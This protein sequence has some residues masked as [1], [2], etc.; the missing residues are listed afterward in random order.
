[1]KWSLIGNVASFGQ[2]YFE[3]LVIVVLQLILKNFGFMQ[4]TVS[5]PFLK[6]IQ[7]LS[8]TSLI[9][10]LFGV[11]FLNFIFRYLIVTS[12]AMSSILISARLRMH[13]Y[14]ELLQSKKPKFIPASELNYR[15]TELAQRTAC[16][17][18]LVVDL[19]NVL[20]QV[21]VYIAIMACLSWKLTLIGLCALGLLG[22]V[23]MKI[24][25]SIQPFS[26]Q[27]PPEVRAINKSIQRIAR[28]WLLVNILRTNNVE[29]EHLINKELKYH[30]LNL[31]IIFL[32]FLSSELP[33]ILGSG[34]IVGMII[35][36][37]AIFQLPAHVLISFVYL[38][39]RLSQTIG[40]M[41]Q[42]M[43]TLIAQYPFFKETLD[44]YDV[45]PND[46]KADAFRPIQLIGM[47]KPMTVYHNERIHLYRNL[48]EISS[49]PCIEI[50]NVTFSY[51]S[52]AKTIFENL[53]LKIE[54]GEQ[55]GI[56]GRSGA[57]K[58][59]ILG[60]I[61]GLLEPQ[62]GQVLINNEL[63][64]SFF[65]KYKI[66]VGYVGPEPFLIEGTLLDNLLYGCIYEKPSDGQINHALRM[67][68]LYDF[69][70]T[71]PGKLYYKVNENGDGLSAGQKQRLALARSLLLNPKLVIL[72]EVSA[73]LDKET[74]FEITE[75]L[76]DLRGQCT[77]II[78]SHK[79][80]ILKYATNVINLD[81]MSEIKLNEIAKVS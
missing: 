69:I 44:H 32:Y 33:R 43:G 20:A 12:G 70:Q 1:M 9:I 25:N 17:C 13:L 67:A 37:G 73:N 3:F 49:S 68:Q 45:V 22:A 72:D 50:K 75:T 78:V 31:R 23:L 2:G 30:M 27:M 56:I 63:S 58:T 57:G 26:E 4:E 79:P 54:E 48:K 5:I 60:L 74:E 81:S 29:Y 7:S 52:A 38:F 46:E 66:K 28:N 16:F 8:N 6:Q 47:N 34:L 36:N 24:N 77:T 14:Y 40:S 18:K 65:S 11:L 76:K 55:A 53:N 21:L 64:G 15:I 51:N 61:L 42:S 19:L 41:S 39:L 10:G 80:G 71:V 35:V 59:T 62:K